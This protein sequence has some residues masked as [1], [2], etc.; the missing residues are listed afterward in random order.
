VFFTEHVISCVLLDGVNVFSPF[1]FFNR[2]CKV[3]QTS[4]KLPEVSIFYKLKNLQKSVKG[5]GKARV[6]VK[7]LPMDTNMALRDKH[8]Y[9]QQHVVLSAY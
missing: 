4:G 2:A 9:A 5:Q 6:T 8:F 7:I 3:L 1:F